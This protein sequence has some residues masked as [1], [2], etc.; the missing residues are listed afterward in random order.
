[1]A[2]RQHH[3]VLFRGGTAEGFLKCMI[4]DISIDTQES[5]IFEQNFLNIQA[6]LETQRMS[7]SGVDEDEEAMNLIKFQNAYNLSSKMVSVM[8]EIYE[9]LIEETGV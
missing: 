8:S 9:K 7:V 4:S 3:T 5:K 1:M 2:D 6:T